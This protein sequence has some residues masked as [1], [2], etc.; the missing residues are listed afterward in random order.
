MNII[1]GVAEKPKP[2]KNKFVVW[3]KENQTIIN[4]SLKLL[5][6]GL[7][8]VYIYIAQTQ[9]NQSKED[10]VNVRTQV[11]T[12][13][14][15]ILNQLTQVN[16]VFEKLG[17]IDNR[18]SPLLTDD[19]NIKLDIIDKTSIYLRD[20]NLTSLIVTN[21]ELIN[22]N[23]MIINDMQ[24]LYSTINGDIASTSFNA[25]WFVSDQ[26]LNTRPDLLMNN[27]SF[28]CIKNYIP[29]SPPYST[30][31]NGYFNP[32]DVSIWNIGSN[33]CNYTKWSLLLND[34]QFYVSFNRSSIC[35]KYTHSSTLRTT[36]QFK[37]LTIPMSFFV[38]ASRPPISFYK[39]PKIL[40][41]GSD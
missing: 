33:P 26:M 13:N 16:N 27:G 34:G 10:L 5:S 36:I 30:Y 32:D 40:R 19:F 21:R 14:A 41:A 29:A 6:L 4:F 28:W 11:S 7:L 18:V 31:N 37:E 35:I 2:H 8:S 12:F 23:L 3:F 39:C 1:D 25:T 24:N 20:N 17:V 38:D 9:I 22:K 15:L